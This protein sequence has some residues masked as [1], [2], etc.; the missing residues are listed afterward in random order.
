MYNNG[1]TN[2]DNKRSVCLEEKEQADAIKSNL[3]K[4]LHYERYR[5]DDKAVNEN[6]FNTPVNTYSAEN[7]ARYSAPVMSDRNAY[8]EQTIAMPTAGKEE[9]TEN[10]RP[11]STTMQFES[12]QDNDIFEDVG[13]KQIVKHEENFSISGKGKLLIAVYALVVA[14]ILSLVIINSRMLRS[15]DSSISAFGTK[16]E[17]LNAEYAKISEEL[18]VANGEEAI[19]KWATEHGYQRNA[20]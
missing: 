4:I 16:I 9:N 1:Q 11:T 15:L 7:N 12:S 14:L 3:D 6:K 19:S 20:A 10:L 2:F 17:N 13:Y 5:T 8:S 18:D